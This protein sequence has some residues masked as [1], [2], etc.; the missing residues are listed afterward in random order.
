MSKQFSIRKTH[1]RLVALRASGKDSTVA[2]AG[3]QK[4][5]NQLS[6]GT[7]G[8]ADASRLR[9][10]MAYLLE[11]SRVG[12]QDMWV[13]KGLERTGTRPFSG[14]CLLGGESMRCVGKMSYSRRHMHY[15][16]ANDGKHIMET[17]QV[18]QFLGIMSAWK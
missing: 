5:L 2:E 6:G 8:K 9:D 18:R 15:F 10:D 7:V 16:W 1:A 4:V 17:M 13:E 3:L 11:A 14:L 12:R